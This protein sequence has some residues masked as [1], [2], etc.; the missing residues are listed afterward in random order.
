MGVFYPAGSFPGLFS[1]RADPIPFISHRTFFL[2]GFCSD[3]TLGLCLLWVRVLCSTVS[4]EGFP[5]RLHILAIARV[6]PPQ[7][8]RGPGH[9]LTFSPFLAS[10]PQ[11]YS[12]KSAIENMDAMELD[13]RMRLAELQRRYKE[14][15][16]ELVKLQRRRDSE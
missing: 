8:R 16:R 11:M 6:A 10:P 3:T 4:M 5:A 1:L 2:G 14:K 12:I 7:S 9:V 13:Y 15:Q